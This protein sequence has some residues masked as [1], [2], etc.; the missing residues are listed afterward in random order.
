MNPGGWKWIL[1]GILRRK[2][3]AA[4]GAILL[5]AVFISLIAPMLPLADP[6][7]T[8]L[9]NRLQPPGTEGHW[10]GTDLLGRDILS[11]LIHG[12][13]LSMAV[14]AAATLLAAGVGS[15]IGICAGYFGGRLDGALMRSIDLL[16]ALPY[17]LLALCIV[18]V[19]GPGLFNA[20]LA[21]SVVNIPFFARTVRGATVLLRGR[22][23]VEASRVCG[24]T[25]PGIL[26]N[27]VLPNVVPVI[28]ITSA[29]TLGWMI[30]ET[31]GLSFL[32]LG[33][34]PPQA[35]LG[36]MLGEGRKLMLIAPHLAL[37]PGAVVF[38]LVMGINL[39]ADGLR[40]VL[41]PRAT[42]Q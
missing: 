19:L 27:Q 2:F 24:R 29:T 18:A 7:A 15:V 5:V 28:L 6:A 23:F 35:D 1:S 14:A 26:L 9:A 11:R 10:L 3:A 25:E 16:M 41:D 22:Q 39:F 13:R 42:R 40:D 32:G 38:I 33:A 36:A 30:L 34:Q 37:L 31:A 20:L 8:D 17:L 4:G 12:T 21:I